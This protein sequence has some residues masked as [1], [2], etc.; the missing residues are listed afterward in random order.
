VKLLLENWREYLNEEESGKLWIV[1][2]PPGVGK[3]YSVENPVKALGIPG[4][5]VQDM[6]YIPAVESATESYMTALG[7][8]PEE[9]QYTGSP[10]V[11][12]VTAAASPKANAGINDFINQHAGQDIFMVGIAWFGPE[13]PFDFPRHA[14]KM[15]LFKD[16]ETIIKQ[17]MGRDSPGKEVS[18]ED[19]QTAIADLEKENRLYEERGWKRMSSDDIINLVRSSYAEDTE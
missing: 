11:Q 5:I 16:P 4:L 3:T 13:L 7:S 17:K 2:G 18:Q 9:E 14:Q 1:A 6:D 19:I 12:K 15:Y 8:L 10:S